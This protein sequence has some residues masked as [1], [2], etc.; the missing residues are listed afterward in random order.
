[1]DE[2]SGEGILGTITELFHGLG[3]TP[4]MLSE[5]DGF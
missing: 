3:L 2:H 5:S 4:E 1:M